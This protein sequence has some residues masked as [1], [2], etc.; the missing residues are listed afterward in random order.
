MLRAMA[1]PSRFQAIAGPSQWHGACNQAS[2]VADPGGSTRRITCARLKRDSFL[3]LEACASISALAGSQPPP[4]GT[5]RKL[6]A[7]KGECIHSGGLNE[8]ENRL[9]V[10]S[11][12]LTQSANLVRDALL[13]RPHSRLSVASSYW[14]L[15]SLSVRETDQI[16]A[17]VLDLSATG[18][19]LRRRAKYI[20]QTWPFAAILIYGNDPEGLRVA[21]YD[22]R[23]PP[24]TD[25]GDLLNTM[26]R[27]VAQKRCG[28]RNH[29]VRNS[30]AL[31]PT[32]QS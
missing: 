11:V 30:G 4:T 14:D 19:E 10:V 20:R 23:V 6:H 32:F 15:C 27:L 18:R 3:D 25:P 7:A 21:H 29:D 12:G 5:V 31:H 13:L 24:G 22:G 28:G 2:H 9:R 17:A 8:M 16:S 26:E 1:P